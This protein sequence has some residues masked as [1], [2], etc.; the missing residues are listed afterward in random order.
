MTSVNIPEGQTAVKVSVIDNG[1]R[2]RGPTSLFIE[3]PILDHL[4]E[5]GAAAPAYVFLIEHEKLQRKVVFDLG[6]RKDIQGYAPSVLEYHKA[7]TIQSGLDVFEVLQ[8]GGIDL[9]N[10]EAIIWRFVVHQFGF[11]SRNLTIL[12]PSP[13]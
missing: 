7:F 8:A 3:P 6:I 11:L 9:N 4:E 2:I 1:A 10:I 5:T 12:Q 13:H